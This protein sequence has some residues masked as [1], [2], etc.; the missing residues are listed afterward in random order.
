MVELMKKIFNFEVKEVE[1]EE[2]TLS[3][4]G[5]DETPD[6][7]DDVISVD[8]WELDNYLKNPVFMWAHDY[9]QPPIGKAVEVKKEDRKLRF[10]IKF[11]DKDTYPFAN[12]I[13]KLYRGGFMKATSVGFI[14]HKTEPR[15][16]EEGNPI[17]RG[18]NFLS[19]E[20]LELSAVPIPCNPNALVDSFQK[21]VFNEEELK[22]MEDKFFISRKEREQISEK[23]W[24]DEPDW[25]EIRY[26]VRNP[27]L[28][29]RI[30]RAKMPGVN[31]FMLVGPLKTD[32]TG[33]T[34]IQALRFPK[35]EWTLATA[36]KWVADHPDIG[37]GEL[38]PEWKDIE[39]VDCDI[40]G[41]AI[42]KGI[43][44]YHDYGFDSENAPWSAS[45]ET[46]GTEPDVLKKICAW[47][48]SA[49]PDIRASYKLPHH[50][51]DGGN[52]AVWGGVR[53]AM[54]ALLGG[55]GGIDVPA[56]DRKGIF[57]HLKRHYVHWDKEAPEFREY[58][59]VELAKLFP[60]IKIEEM[61]QQML[62]AVDGMTN[63]I[64]RMAIEL[65][66]TK[67]N[68]TEI[69]S[70]LPEEG[71]VVTPVN[72]GDKPKGET[73][74]ESLYSAILTEGKGINDKLNPKP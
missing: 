63:T 49:N 13:F 55:R 35:P 31:I 46:V 73:E 71:K 20:L 43:I 62:V 24:E 29:V 11:A 3:F 38:L 39:E 30:R 10:N 4:T 72:P 22:V 18:R 50:R 33:G 48:D 57:N 60:E 44:P 2:N 51:K 61:I 67:D 9:K 65:G 7:D 28:F 58:S 52:K 54:G 26:R 64:S 59:A 19:Q 68:V 21:G 37:K 6:R 47:V 56:G 5:S 70:R 42:E 17:A 23:I 53:A 40:E 41:D 8:G 36:K 27:D 74:G 1:G 12:T 34:K 25:T 14:P 69:L 45:A 32:P 66:L 16:D 15:L